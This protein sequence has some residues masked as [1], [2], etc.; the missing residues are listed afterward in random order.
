M[1]VNPAMEQLHG[2]IGN[3]VAT[4]AD[5]Q[6]LLHT[7]RAEIFQLGNPTNGRQTTMAFEET[8]NEIESLRQEVLRLREASINGQVAHANPVSTPILNIKEPKVSMPEKFDGTRSKLRGF[9][10]QVKLFLRLHP[11]RYPDG[12]TQV[13]FVGTL[14]SSTTLSWFAPLMERNSPLLNDL[15]AFLE[16]LTATFGDSDRERV[17]E[18]KIQTLRQGSRSAAIY[19]AE[20]QQLACDLDWNDKALMNHFRR[21]L[22]DNVKDLLLTMPRVNTLEEFITQAISCDNR[23]FERRQEQRFGWRGQHQNMVATSS[24]FSGNHSSGPEPMQIDTT[25]FKR[26]TQEE[27]D[28]RRREGLCL[29]CGKPGHKAPDCRAKPSEF[30]ARGMTTH[31]E[32]S[33]N[34]DVQLQ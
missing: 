22:N 24:K 14:L 4:T 27:K 11:L 19:A 30:K 12:T 33:E 34:K 13:G 25:R 10:Q 8:N 28:R 29:Y 6:E 31:S 18:T 3:R 7:I 16:A 32:K 1:E 9:V 21:G 15:D 23:L 5:L 26:L 20:F 17:A 2:E